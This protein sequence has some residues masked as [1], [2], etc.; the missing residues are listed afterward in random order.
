MGANTPSGRKEKHGDPSR[1]SQVSSSSLKRPGSPNLSEASGNESSRKKVKK[2][3]GHSKSGTATPRPDGLMSRQPSFAL[4]RAGSGSETE[5]NKS[6]RPGQKVRLVMSPKG[7]PRGSRAASPA[8]GAT[9]KSA[10]G[11]RAASPPNTTG[12]IPTKEEVRAQIPAGGISIKNL[13]NVF[14]GRGI[15]KEKQMDFIRLVRE[16]A[17]TNKETGLLVRRN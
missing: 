4:G 2:Q 7:T 5:G 12:V 6:S 10:G 17:T 9:N 15:P 14:K 3:H 13:S 11:S 16:V 8:T 1:K